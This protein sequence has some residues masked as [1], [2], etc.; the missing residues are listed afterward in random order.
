MV[1]AAASAALA[2]RRL[3]EW[4]L[5]AFSHFLNCAAA[6]SFLCMP[7]HECEAT[8]LTLTTTCFSSS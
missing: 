8:S 6:S 7:A 2:P 4:S 5:S 3:R 1:S